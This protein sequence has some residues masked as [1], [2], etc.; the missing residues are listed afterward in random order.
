MESIKKEEGKEHEKKLIGT[1]ILLLC[2][3]CGAV[4]CHKPRDL[5]YYD[6]SFVNHMSDTEVLSPDGYLWLYSVEEQTFS[7][8]GNGE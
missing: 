1:V 8:Y 6:I 7:K 5:R 4:G 3:L 2:F